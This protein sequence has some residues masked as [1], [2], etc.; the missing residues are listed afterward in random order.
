MGN[1]TAIFDMRTS[2][3][4]FRDCWRSLVSLYDIERSFIQLSSL[5]SRHSS[6]TAAAKTDLR[7][8]EV[9]IFPIFKFLCASVCVCVCV[10]V[11]VYHSISAF[12]WLTQSLLIF[13]CIWRH[14]NPFQY[15]V[16]LFHHCVCLMSL[17]LSRLDKGSV[18]PLRQQ[19]HEKNR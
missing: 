13:I 8:W 9:R 14:L 18:K 17:C 10:S 19:V 16:S 5:S 4:R 15:M 1:V 2:G 7:V 11:S 6:A 12:E 3:M